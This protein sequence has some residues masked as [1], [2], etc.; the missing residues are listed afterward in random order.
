MKASCWKLC[1]C[2]DIVHC[3]FFSSAVSELAS[4]C[5]NNPICVDCTTLHKKT[6][7]TQTPSQLQHY[8]AIIPAKLRLV[9]AVAI[10]QNTSQVSKIMWSGI[11][12]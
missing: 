1:G 4:V 10:V 3:L 5:L 9:A 7:A 11:I 6:I 8:F 2:I 12:L